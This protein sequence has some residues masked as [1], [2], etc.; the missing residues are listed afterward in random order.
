MN[1]A[2]TSIVSSDPYEGFADFDPMPLMRAVQYVVTAGVDGHF[3]EFGSYQGRSAEVL[4]REL[5]RC[6]VLY[7]I[8]E[9]ANTSSERRLFLFEGFEGFPQ[10]TNPVD[11]ASPHIARGI[12]PP[13]GARGG[14]PEQLKER[15]ARHLSEDRIEIFPGWFKDTVKTI[16][17]DARFALLHVDCDL[18]QSTI[19]ALVPIFARGM[20]TDGAT[21]LFD[22]W[23]CNSGSPDFGQQR[24]WR[25][26][27]TAFYRYRYTDYGGYGVVGRRFIVHW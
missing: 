23:Y 14:S 21:I 19:D 3:A 2:A 13:G 11:L 17:E 16:P 10:A 9:K 25:E 27:T 20:I 15:C 4:A 24:A 5:A 12:W 22:D 8:N 6:S 7:D 1:E 18:Y 26:I